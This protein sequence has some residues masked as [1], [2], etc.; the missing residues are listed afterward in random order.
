LFIDAHTHAFLPEDLKVLKERLL[1]LD[2][3][4]E[5]DD[6]N[7]WKLFTEGDLE[8]LLQGMAKAEA[9]HFILLPVTGKITRISELNRWAAEVAAE[10]PQVIPF[11]ILHPQGEVEKDLAELMALGLKGVKLHPLTQRFNLEHPAT[12][13][14]FERIAE[15]GLPVLVDTMSRRG[16]LANKPHVEWMVQMAGFEGSGPGLLAPLA[17]AHPRVPIIA[18]HGGS[19]YGWDRIEP[20]FELDNVYFDIS[21]LSGLIEPAKVLEIIRRRSPEKVIYGSDAPWRDP[22]AYR[23]WFEDLR[24]SPG[25]REQVS[26]GTILSL[27]E[28]R[29][30]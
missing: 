10:H 13:A 27:L 1:F 21:C 25:E 9:D 18:A 28:R 3:H 12:H 26:G 14:M 11:G 7:R 29:A 17:A 4:L 16:L 2:A 5:Q 19:L 30:A 15:T 24:L 6:P 22:V 23:Q 20:L 8:S